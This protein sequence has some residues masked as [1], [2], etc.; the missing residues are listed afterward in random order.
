M[1]VDSSLR[2]DDNFDNR[3]KE[4]SKFFLIIIFW[5]NDLNSGLRS[6]KRFQSFFK[7]GKTLALVHVWSIF[8]FSFI[9]LLVRK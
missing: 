9:A 7:K 3:A 2:C 1:R 5:G 8:S 4:C 6:D